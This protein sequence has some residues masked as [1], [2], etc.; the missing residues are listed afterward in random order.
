MPAPW[1]PG[2][3]AI[4]EPLTSAPGARPELLARQPDARSH[5]MKAITVRIVLFSWSIVAAISCGGNP[6]GPTTLDTLDELLV[7]LRAQGLSATLAGEISP[8]VNRF[9]SVPAQQ[10]LVNGSRVS[11]FE[12]PTADAAAAEAA[13]VSPTGQPNPRAIIDWVSTAHFYRKGQ[14]IALYAGCSTETLKALEAAL[15]PPFVVDRTPCRVMN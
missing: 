12:Y 14:L 10:V 4:S 5:T 15:G 9:F 8:D 13:M 7:A 6:T 2:K 1:R 3:E 11:V